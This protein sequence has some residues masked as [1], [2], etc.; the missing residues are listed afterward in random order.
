M[1]NFRE[2]TSNVYWIGGS[3]KRLSLFENLFPIPNGVSYNSYFISD[4][5][6]AVL[7]TVDESVKDIFIDNVKELTKEKSLDYIIIQHMEPDHSASLKDL[8]S[9][10]P[11]ATLVM[12]SKTLTIF[13]QFFG[14]TDSKIQFVSDGEILSLGKRSLKFIM[15]PMVHWPEVMMSYETESGILFSADAFGSFGA[16]EGAVFDGEA[17]FDCSYIMEMRRYYSNIV[18]KYGAQVLKTL[19]AAEALDIKMICP[20]HGLVLKEKLSFVLDKYIKWANYCPEEKGVVIVYAS[21][22]NN[23]KKA[24]F[25]MANRLSGEKIKVEV[26]DA[27]NTDVSYLISEI[28]RFSHVILA[29]VTYNGGIYPKMENLIADIKALGII[30]RTFYFMENGSWA[31]ASARLMKT[32]LE[33]MKNTVLSDNVFSI[34][35]AMKD[36]DYDRFELFINGIIKDVNG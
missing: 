17:D 26:F 8:I 13:E 21:M 27:S 29:S 14:K 24:A 19:K 15:A 34:R 33:T 9:L 20:L 10:C 11:D 30:N 32:A 25:E 36:C 3:D 6:T 35:S 18:G 23:T 16:I 12:N 28:F 4:E 2:L 22:Y 31:P 5:K 1:H 7:D